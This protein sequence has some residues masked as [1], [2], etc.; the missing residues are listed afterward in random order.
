MGN[1]QSKA[2]GSNMVNS[3]VSSIFNE[4]SL[5]CK[6]TASSNQDITVGCQHADPNTKYPNTD[7][8]P[9]PF[10]NN[11]S[12]TN[13]IRQIEETRKLYYSTQKAQWKYKPA[14]VMLP[15]DQDYHTIITKFYDCGL[16]CKACWY[17]DLNE[18][19]LV[20]M[21]LGCKS[22]N[23]ISNQIDQKL[24][25]K[26]KQ[27]LTNNLGAATAAAQMLGTSSS[28]KLVQ[29]L[30]TRV[31]S[32]ITEEVIAGV[33]Q[34]I[35]NNQNIYMKNSKTTHTNTRSSFAAITTYFSK[36][37][38][39]STIFTDE[40]W[41]N[42]EKLYNDQNTIGGLGQVV[43]SGVSDITK[44]IKSVVGKI[45]VFMLITVGV[46][47]L[48]II[49]YASISKIRRYLSKKSAQ[50]QKRKIQEKRMPDFEQF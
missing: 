9:E 45:V 22:F 40:Q 38:L 13:C 49:S 37:N 48:S 34:T 12:C 27:T 32:K 8:S 47:L 24:S 28:Q 39:F 41:Q 44:M 16:Q 5:T 36:T 1:G 25:N 33:S 6:T 29:N 14:T 42:L 2:V 10:E 46:V 30:V 15:I 19:T 7:D 43:V 18:E 3:M 26:I 21:S 4:V 31:S 11:A 20:D 23:S 17:M 35:K 50:Y